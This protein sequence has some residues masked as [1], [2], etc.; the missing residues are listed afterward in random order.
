MATI[1]RT[2]SEQEVDADSI[3]FHLS[4]L[5]EDLKNFITQVSQ[6]LLTL[7]GCIKDI[8]WMYLISD[9]GCKQQSFHLDNTSLASARSDGVIRH[10]NVNEIPFSMLISLEESEDNPTAIHFEGGYRIG[11][12]ET[13]AKIRPGRCII[14]RGDKLHGG[15]AYHKLNARLFVG[16]GTFQYPYVHDDVNVVINKTK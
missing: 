8:K 11:M 5:P 12:Q 1:N 9:S 3:L 6:F 13:I 4:D 2:N 15:A 16:V 14:W 10:P 7:N